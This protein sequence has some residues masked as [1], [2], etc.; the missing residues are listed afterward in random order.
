M[1]SA[2]LFERLETLV[3]FAKARAQRGIYDG[4][5]NARAKRMIDLCTHTL[6][7]SP[8]ETAWI[9]YTRDIGHHSSGWWK[10]PDYERCY[11]LS[12]SFRSFPGIVMMPFRQDVAE[13]IARAF[14]GHDCSKAWIEGPWS[15]EGKACDV[16]HYRLFVDKT[17]CPILPRREVYSKD[18]TPAD[19]RSFSEIH[20]FT[21]EPEQAP[22]L[23]GAS[24]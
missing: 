7:V 23:L 18:D 11:H 21:P 14:W 8:I 1:T 6:L 24:S 4:V 15:A 9:I 3:P 22:F 17:W 2:I 12:F 19:W 13:R 20:G 16:H 10:N 5:A